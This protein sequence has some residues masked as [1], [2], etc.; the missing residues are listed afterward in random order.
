M[1]MIQRRRVCVSPENALYLLSVT[2][3]V[4]NARECS[5]VWAEVPRPAHHAVEHRFPA[6]S[7]R[8]ERRRS[9]QETLVFFVGTT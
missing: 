1:T 9:P 5:K 3:R 7:A 6:A 2:V 8:L 4:G